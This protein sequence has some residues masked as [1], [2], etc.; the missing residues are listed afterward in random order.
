M[1]IVVEHDKRR[2]EILYKAIKVFEAEGF[3]DVTLQKIADACGIT[4]TTLYIYFKNKSEIF[5]F[6]IKQLTS[7][8]EKALQEIIARKTLTN[9]QKLQ[10]IMECVISKCVEY[11]SLF[12][13]LLAYLL[14]LQKTGT[15]VGERVR[16]RI[17]RLRHLLSTVLIEGIKTGEFK[18]INV[19]ATNELFYSLIES[20]IFRISLLNQ[21]NVD[22]LADAITLAIDGIKA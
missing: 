3:D 15:D 11:Q 22:E 1:A 18:D 4:R 8:I 13:V 5:L 7:E 10:A 14:K 6:S 16:R 12:N 9:S 19:K 2:K 20:T 17:L 21:S